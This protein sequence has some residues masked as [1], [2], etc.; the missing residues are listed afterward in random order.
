[1]RLREPDSMNRLL[2]RALRY[3]V[4]LS[5]AVLLVGTILLAASIGSDVIDPYVAYNPSQVPHSNFDLSP[6]AFARDLLALKPFAVIELGVFFLIA[7]PVSRVTLSALLF[8]AERDRTYVYIT[9]GVLALL[10]FSMLVT[11]LIP[12]F[13][14]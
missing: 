2:S 1:M 8:A 4:V 7:T 13:N 5:A 11:P 12:G 9:L 14:R 10:L 6:D 3:G